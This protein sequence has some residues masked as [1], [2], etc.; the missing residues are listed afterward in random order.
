[1]LDEADP[2]DVNYNLEVTS[3]GIERV[4]RKPEHILA[5][6]GEKVDVSLYAKIDDRRTFTGVL[7]SY[8][9]EAKSF[10]LLTEQG[11]ITLPLEKV[12]K[13]RTKFDF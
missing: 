7:E 12:S 11:G 9:A 5:C 6:L 3:P 1:L 8:D 10:V 4:L 13:M 2:I